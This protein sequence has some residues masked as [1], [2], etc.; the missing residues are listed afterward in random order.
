MAEL[1]LML[2]FTIWR[3]SESLWSICYIMH[4]SQ[5]HFFFLVV[6]IYW[7]SEFS[8]DETLLLQDEDGWMLDSHAGLML[9]C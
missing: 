4:N 5:T 1:K 8:T 7:M 3:V 6:C 9:V 2:F